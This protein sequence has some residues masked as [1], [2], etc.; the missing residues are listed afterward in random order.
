M[1]LSAPQLQ[2]PAWLRPA[3]LGTFALALLAKEPAMT[4][5]VLATAYE[6]FYRE[7]R[8]V[9]AWTEKVSRYIVSGFCFLPISACAL[10]RSVA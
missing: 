8:A 3:M 1:R 9:I 6:H 4:F 7:D 10:P 2:R 5:P